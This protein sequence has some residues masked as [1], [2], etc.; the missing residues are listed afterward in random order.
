MTTTEM[1]KSLV[2][3]M[4]RY[5]G[6]EYELMRVEPTVVLQSV[7]YG[8][9]VEL[10]PETFKRMIVDGSIKDIKETENNAD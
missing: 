6:D 2:G 5:M 8:S 9:C 1:I 7:H 4:F 3:R 10:L